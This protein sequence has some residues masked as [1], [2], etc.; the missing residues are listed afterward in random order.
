MQIIGRGVGSIV[1]MVGVIKCVFMA[2]FPPNAPAVKPFRQLL[3]KDDVR[4]G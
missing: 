4:G 3:V 1:A 2:D